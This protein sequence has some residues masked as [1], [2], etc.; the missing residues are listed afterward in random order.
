MT[1]PSRPGSKAGLPLGAG[2]FGL[3]LS[4]A[5]P[6]WAQ[7][8][9]VQ[10]QES[11]AQIPAISETLPGSAQNQG[12]SLVSAVVTLDQ[13]ALFTGS[14]FGQRVQHQ[15]ERDRD[16]LTLENRRIEAELVE[17]ELAL[18]EIRDSTA[19]A[20]FTRLANAFDEKV[21][22]VREAQ[23]GK[24]ILLQ[25]RLERERQNFWTEAGPAI[26][27]VMRQKGALVVIDRNAI[28][29][30]FDGVDI[31]QDAIAAIDTAIGAGKSPNLPLAVPAQRPERTESTVPIAPS[32]E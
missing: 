10:G 1:S 2:V 26:A 19:V 14:A 28:L 25:Q 5:S 17:E 16:A 29:L 27:E 8:Q 23:D 3:C 15:L 4:L 24:S 31:T 30:A 18:T 21:R 20:E 22:Q 32:L 13:D 11:P 6:L 9:I 12:L 7:S